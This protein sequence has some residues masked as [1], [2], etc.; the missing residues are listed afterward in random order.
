M[1]DLKLV[2]HV[3]END[4][5]PFTMRSVR[6]LVHSKESGKAV[7]VANGAAVRSFSQLDADPARI[8]QIRD[9]ARKD[10]VRFM[11]CNIALRERQVKPELIPEYV[12]IVPSGI[13]E[14]AKF[15][16]AGYGYIKA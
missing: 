11:V 9:L 7:V 15:Q 12:E 1:A 16:A 6:N 3:N 4:R 10:G 2:F 8:S 14:I 13:V 5:W